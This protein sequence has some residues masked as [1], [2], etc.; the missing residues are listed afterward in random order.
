MLILQWLGAIAAV[1]GTWV[2]ATAVLVG[3]GLLVRPTVRDRG[4]VALAFWMGFAGV[5]GLLQ[6]WH[7][8]LPID[9]VTQIAVIA[10]GGFGLAWRGRRL[11][12]L[13]PG[14]RTTLALFTLSLWLANR[15]IGPGDASDSGLYHYH[16]MAWYGEHAIVPGSANLHLRLGF[17]HG[18]L[19]FAALCDAGPW[20]GR[21]EHVASGLTLLGIGGMAVAALGR[22][23]VG[24]RRPA[25]IF[26]TLLVV[27][28]TLMALGKE[29]SSPRT[30][31]PAAA[32]ALIAV[33]QLLRTDFDKTAAFVLVGLLPVMKLSVAAIGI[34]VWIAAVASNMN[35]RRWALAF[36]VPLLFVP[37]WLV[38]GAVLSG[39]PLFPADIGAVSVDWKLPAEIVDQEQANIERF[40]RVGTAGLV[41][42]VLKREVDTSPAVLE[43]FRWV[44]NWAL[45]VGLTGFVHV[46]CPLV[47]GVAFLAWRR[48]LALALLPGVLGLLVWFFGAPEPRF[49]MA[50]AWCFGAAAIALARPKSLTVSMTVTVGLALTVTWAAALQVKLRQRNPLE[51]IPLI[52]P[53]DGGFH[54]HEAVEHVPFT[55]NWGTRIMQ[56]EPLHKP[57]RGPLLSTGFPH[58]DLRLRDPNDIAAGFQ[59]V[60]HPTAERHG[61]GVTFPSDGTNN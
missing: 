17:N 22:M 27:P 35:R 14:R 34:G 60:E 31:W 19:L 33:W 40:S 61:F 5:I 57:W 42:R 32:V 44:P 20:E 10:I 41:G 2:V 25:I 28:V 26:A 55:T 12:P 7:F 51:V 59:I 53:T 21:G 38:R 30:D 16:T 46:V 36:V 15:A 58:R 37:P 13:R 18:F 24:D 6:F 23:W 45:A 43:N 39:H 56:P 50:A 8:V 11:W 29:A 3:I 52:L 9:G 49:G 4:D 47:F 48:R 1:W 54:E